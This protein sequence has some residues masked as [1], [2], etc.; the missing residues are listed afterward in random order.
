MAGLSIID[1]I[2]AHGDSRAG[3]TRSTCGSVFESTAGAPDTAPRRR[4]DLEARNSDRL[5]APLAHAVDPAPQSV[6]G[7]VEFGD[8]EA[9]LIEERRNLRPLESNGRAFRVMLVVEV[10]GLGRLDDPVEHVAQLDDTAARAVPGGVEDNPGID[11]VRGELCLD[12]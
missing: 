1:A 7:V 6:L 3:P 4:L 10:R 9:G 5:T 2:A 8:L 11:H 12:L